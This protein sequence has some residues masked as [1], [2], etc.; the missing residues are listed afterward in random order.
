MLGH[1]T[2]AATEHYLPS[3]NAERIFEINS[4]LL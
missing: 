2:S 1:S 3:I 4:V